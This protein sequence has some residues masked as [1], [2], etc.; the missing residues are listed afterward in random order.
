MLNSSHFRR[1]H[2]LNK[3]RVLFPLLLGY[4]SQALILL[5]SDKSTEGARTDQVKTN[6]IVVTGVTRALPGTS[7]EVLRCGSHCGVYSIALKY[8]R[9][10][11]SERMRKYRLVVS[12]FTYSRR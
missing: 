11:R 2:P 3:F 4:G 8:S 10:L 9:V 12:G 7:S 6:R 1:Q 5:T